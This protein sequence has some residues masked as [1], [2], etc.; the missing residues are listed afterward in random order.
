MKGFVYRNTK[1]IVWPDAYQTQARGMAYE[2]DKHFVHVFGKASELWVV[3]NGLTIA[4]VKSGT[5][6][7]WIVSNFGAV[8]IEECD[9]AVGETVMGV[10]R[11][12]LFY[13]TEMLQGLAGTNAELRDSEQALLLL[14][15]RLDELLLFVEPS[16][17][18]F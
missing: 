4:E 8:E 16:K 7:D 9:H 17:K 2:T 14:V 5:L 1:S 13:D 10:W 11:P 18:T 15:Q 3:S 12:G 6:R